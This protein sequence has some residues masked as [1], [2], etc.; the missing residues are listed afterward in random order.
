MRRRPPISTRTDT[1]FPYTTLF[2]SDQHRLARREF[3][4]DRGFIIRM[5]ALDRVLQTFGRGDVDARVARVARQVPLRAGFE[6]QRR[7]GKPAEPDLD[8]I[9]AMLPR[10][11]G[12]VQP[13]VPAFLTEPKRAVW[14]ELAA[15]S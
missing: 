7:D 8:L 15:V 5:H 13:G 12:F 4:D 10:G 1:L 9:D 6:R 2:R 3:G 14:G 11:L